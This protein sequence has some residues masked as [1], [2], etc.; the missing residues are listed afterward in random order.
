VLRGHK[1]VISTVCKESCLSRV[2]LYLRGMENIVLAMNEH[3]VELPMVT[4][5]GGMHPG[6]ERNNAV[7]YEHLIKRI[8]LRGE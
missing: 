6:R 5:S 7:F 1:A 8:L 2:S 3:D 4:S